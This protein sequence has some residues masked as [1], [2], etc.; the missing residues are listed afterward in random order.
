LGQKHEGEAT[1][2]AF[3]KAKEDN[4]IASTLG[5]LS[6]DVVEDV[7]YDESKKVFKDY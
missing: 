5:K 1:I 2:E 7:N 3:V 6:R 4:S